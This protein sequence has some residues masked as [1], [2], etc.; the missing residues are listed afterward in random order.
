M[1][2]FTLAELAKQTG[3]KLFGNPDASISGVNTLEEAGSSDL[4]FLANSRY[5]EMMKKSCA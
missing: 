1:P 3:S 4:S 2:I 5:R